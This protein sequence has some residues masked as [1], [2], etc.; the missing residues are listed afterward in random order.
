MLQVFYSG[1][2]QDEFSRMARQSVLIDWSVYIFAH[3]LMDK[4]L[5]QRRWTMYIAVV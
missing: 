5:L 3:D 2:V 1:R 4:N